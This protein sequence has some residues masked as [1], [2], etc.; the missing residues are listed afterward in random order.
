MSIRHHIPANA[1][2]PKASTAQIESYL[3][4]CMGLFDVTREEVIAGAV[5]MCG[6]LDVAALA[7]EAEIE[8]GRADIMRAIPDGIENAKCVVMG[9]KPRPGEDV[10]F[11]CLNDN[12][13]IRVWDGDLADMRSFALDFVGGQGRYISTPNGINLIYTVSSTF[14]GPERV[15]SLEQC[16]EGEGRERQA[17]MERY[18]IYSPFNPPGHN[19]IYDKNW[20][21]YIIPEGIELRIMQDGHA[22]RFLPIPVRPHPPTDD[23]LQLQPWQQWQPAGTRNW[24]E[25]KGIVTSS[26]TPFGFQN[27]S[28]S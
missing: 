1:S 28:I 4:M 3:T 6:S 26:S 5:Q 11:V 8:R 20:E 14:R 22:D 18:A 23:V 24:G 12:L 9:R 13:S 17:E 21:T 15:L 27:L 2:T 16:M 19:G 25:L 7:A 10:K